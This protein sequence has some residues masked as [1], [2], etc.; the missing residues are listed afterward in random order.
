MVQQL[1]GRPIF[2]A[3]RDTSTWYDTSILIRSL[4][5]EV[6]RKSLTLTAGV[7]LFLASTMPGWAASKESLVT[8]SKDVAPI[9]YKHCVACHRPDTTAPMSLLQYKDARP[10]AKSMREKVTAREMP[11]WNADPGFGKFKNDPHLT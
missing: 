8:Y 11:P 3:F 5:G 4:E 9:L 1:H 2:R 10:W 6:M 7:A